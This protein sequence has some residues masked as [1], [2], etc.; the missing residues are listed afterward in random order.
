LALAGPRPPAAL[1]NT[2]G[3]MILVDY[4]SDVT[5]TTVVGSCYHGCCQASWSCTG[6]MT[7]Y[8]EITDRESCF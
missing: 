2:C 6:T 5:H 3:D 8:S 7:P 1:A 4:Y